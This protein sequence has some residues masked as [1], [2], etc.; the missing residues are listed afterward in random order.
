MKIS[1]ITACFNSELHIG[2]AIES[3]IMQN[4]P[5]IEHVIVDGLS[6]DHTVD[7]IKKYSHHSGY[8]MKLVS[9]KDSGI[10]NAINKGIS[11]CSGEIIGILHSDDVL[12]DNTV[13][14]NIAKEFYSD[15]EQRIKKSVDIVYGDI[16]YCRKNDLSTLVRYWKSVNYSRRYLLRGWMPPHPSLFLKAAVYKKCG[17]YNESMKISSDYDYILKIFTNESLSFK[18]LAITITKMRTGGVSNRNLKNVIQ[19]SVEDY[20]ALR[21]NRI[22]NPMMV[23]LMK[24]VQKI[25]Q[26]IFDKNILTEFKA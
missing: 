17:P 26:F 16:A 15:Q 6:T 11:L 21:R 24:N 18:Y 14:S 7:I 23:L 4:Y 10:Y 9:E 13:I 22:P 19:K 2:E 5:N 3:I 20:K 25:P 8:M 1:I 12:S